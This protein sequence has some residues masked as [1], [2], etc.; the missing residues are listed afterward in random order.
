VKKASSILL[1]VLVGAVLGG[2][3]GDIRAPDVNINTRQ[4]PPPV[5]T[6][7]EPQTYEEARAAWRAAMQRNEYL[8]REVTKL[9][10]ENRKLK[11]DRNKYKD[12]YED[13]KDRHDD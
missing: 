11:D 3:V 9:Q 10:R 13:L 7:D 1:T 4:E 6:Q 12:R 8:E 5:N 2:C